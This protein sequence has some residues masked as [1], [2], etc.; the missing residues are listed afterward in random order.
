LFISSST[1][2]DRFFELV[3]DAAVQRLAAETT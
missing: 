3:A 1:S 2:A